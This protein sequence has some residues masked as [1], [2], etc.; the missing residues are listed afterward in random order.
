MPE[1][2]VLAAV[3]AAAGSHL[4][5]PRTV[6]LI[7]AV[8][9]VWLLTLLVR[10]FGKCW[11]CRGK[12]VRIV[13]GRRRRKARKCWACKGVGR[14]QRIGSRTV[15]RARRMAMS[16]WRHEPVSKGGA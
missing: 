9:A 5:I 16:A 13:R 12:R 6:L 2:A 1:L 3:P 10:P 15:H 8:V 4:D 14:R 7:V 11:L